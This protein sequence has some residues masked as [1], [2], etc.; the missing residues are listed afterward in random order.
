M[1]MRNVIATAAA[2]AALSFGLV[3]TPA[4]AEGWQH[5]GWYSTQR[6]CITAGQSLEVRYRCVPVSPKWDLQIY[7][8]DV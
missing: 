6:N 2:G 5:F 4:H 8:T 1:R 7:V 3:A